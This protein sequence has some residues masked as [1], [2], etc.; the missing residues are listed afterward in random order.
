MKFKEKIKRIPKAWY[1]P[2]SMV[3]IYFLFSLFDKEVYS[4][5]LNFFI[6]ILLKIIPIFILVFVLMS[7]SN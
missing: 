4:G 2:I 1:F 3:F 6:N 7:I 5:S